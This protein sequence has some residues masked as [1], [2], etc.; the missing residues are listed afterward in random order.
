MMM[1]ITFIMPK[2]DYGKQN[3][4]SEILK[5]NNNTNLDDSYTSVYP[6]FHVTYNI[7]EKRSLQFAISSRVERPG[8]GH[9]GG[10]RQVRPFPREIHSDHFIFLGNWSL[11]Y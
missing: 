3:H 1:V 8:G 6:S 9:H 11:I 5:E 2:M 10:S 4:L 7:T